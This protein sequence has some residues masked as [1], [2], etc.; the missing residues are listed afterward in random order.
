MSILAT[1]RKRD[2][3]PLSG[4]GIISHRVKFQQGTTYV[5]PQQGPVKSWVLMWQ[6]CILYRREA[7]VEPN[8]F[9]QSELEY[10]KRLWKNHSSSKIPPGYYLSLL[11]KLAKSWVLM[12][13]GRT[14]Y[15]READVEPNNLQQTEFESSKR[16]WSNLPSGFWDRQHVT[17][18]VLID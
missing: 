5:Y 12:W 17:P 18:W 4:C 16:L 9:P 7:D 11:Q 2:R 6:G 15:L 8:N 3:D 14:L 1:F 10:R 13:Q